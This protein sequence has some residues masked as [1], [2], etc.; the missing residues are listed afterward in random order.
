MLIHQFSPQKYVSATTM[1]CLLTSP[2]N[3]IRNINFFLFSF[4]KYRDFMFFVISIF[5]VVKE[6]VVNIKCIFML[7]LVFQGVN[8]K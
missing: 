4:L 2:L 3:Y 7:F 6:R 1:E 5:A 8:Q